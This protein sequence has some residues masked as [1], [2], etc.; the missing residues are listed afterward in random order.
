M[1]INP[2]VFSKPE[3][4]P[5]PSVTSHQNQL[6]SWLTGRFLDPNPN[7]LSQNPEVEAGTLPARGLLGKPYQPELGDLPSGAMG[8]DWNSTQ[9][10]AG[11]HRRRTRHGVTG[12]RWKRCPGSQV[13]STGRGWSSS[14]QKIPVDAQ[15]LTSPPREPEMTLLAQGPQESVPAGTLH[16]ESS[17]PSSPDSPPATRVLNNTLV[18]T[19][20]AFHVDRPTTSQIR[21]SCAR[22]LCPFSCTHVPEPGHAR[23]SPHL[24][25]HMS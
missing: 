16:L 6:G 5:V 10:G 19:L 24:L 18:Q 9:R 15:R 25:A 1:S 22:D 20:G 11:G 14:S 3:N 8:E 21:R 23:P 12:A 13:I 2:C 4:P 7:L 17:T